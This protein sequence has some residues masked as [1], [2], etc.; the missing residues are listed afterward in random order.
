ML[1]T[2]QEIKPHNENSLSSTLVLDVRVSPELEKNHI[3]VIHT[4]YSVTVCSLNL[5]PARFPA[6]LV[7]SALANVEHLVLDSNCNC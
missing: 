1:L 6:I 2:D 4:T 7:S 5:N 3:S